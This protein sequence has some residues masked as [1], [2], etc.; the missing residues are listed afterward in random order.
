MLLCCGPVLD[1]AAPAAQAEP[2]AVARAG[3]CALRSAGDQLGALEFVDGVAIQ[4]D[5][6]GAIPVHASLSGSVRDGAG[7]R[8]RI[9]ASLAEAVVRI[10]TQA[11]PGSGVVIAAD[12]RR[13][14]ILT[15]AHVVQ[16]SA[17]QEIVVRLSDGE[18]L[19]VRSIQPFPGSDLAQLS[20][21]SSRCLMAAPLVRSLES[22]LLS[23]TRRTSFQQDVSILG[24]PAASAELKLVKAEALLQSYAD[25]GRAGGYAIMYRYGPLAQTEIGMSGSPV[26][27][28]NGY[29]VGIHGQVDRVGE[30]SGR[31]AMRTGYGLAVPVNVWI[32]ARTANRYSEPGR[33]AVD[34]ALIGAYQLS[35]GELDRSIESL[36]R[37]I[38]MSIAEYRTL[39]RRRADS[40]RRELI[41]PF[42]TYFSAEESCRRQQQQ[43]RQLRSYYPSPYGGF[44]QSGSEAQRVLDFCIRSRQTVEALSRQQRE[45]E[46]SE[47]GAAESSMAAAGA[48]HHLYMLRSLAYAARGMSAE[49]SQD[50][51]RCLELAGRSDAKVCELPDHR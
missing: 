31:T 29:V 21:D 34:H 12:G 2:A 43:E 36:S 10:E 51:Q 13:L 28:Q 16:H 8:V 17:E 44:E 11:S 3:A 20:V 37:A 32:N 6:I 48:Q 50:R 40:Y 27:D 26:F 42:G 19:P 47:R 39:S 49:A 41:E 5:F 45:R 22:D 46:M 23:K 25:Q 24:F 1:P 35:T 30:A 15:S 38:E 4:R 33:T 18:A 7:A 14:T 9:P